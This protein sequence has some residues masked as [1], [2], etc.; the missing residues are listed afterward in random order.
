MMGDRAAMIFAGPEEITKIIE[1]PCLLTGTG[2]I[3]LGCGLRVQAFQ[4]GSPMIDA[5]LRALSM[6]FA[7]RWEILWPL[8]L[9]FLAGEKS[10]L[11]RREFLE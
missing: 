2:S 3:P 5:V 8:I 10:P 9:G 1:A 7:M 6:A 4:G 11:R